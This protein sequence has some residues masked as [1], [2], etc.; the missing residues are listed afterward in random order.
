VCD[1]A[2]WTE[3]DIRTFFGLIDCGF[4]LDFTHKVELKPQNLLHKGEQLRRILTTKGIGT[5]V[6]SQKLERALKILHTY[7]EDQ[8]LIE[9]Y[10]RQYEGAVTVV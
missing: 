5:V 10:L 8:S 4:V 9:E 6:E 2:S 3:D 1:V 7:W